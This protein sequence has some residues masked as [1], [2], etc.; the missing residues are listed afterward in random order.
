MYRH[1]GCGGM[2]ALE[3]VVDLGTHKGTRRTCRTCGASDVARYLPVVD[4]SLQGD[5]QR[6]DAYGLTHEEVAVLKRLAREQIRSRSPEP[7]PIEPSPC[8]SPAQS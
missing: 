4:I 2:I 6:A 5:E 3:P 8:H 1:K 7:L